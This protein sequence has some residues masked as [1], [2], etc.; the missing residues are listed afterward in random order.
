V[1][2]TSLQLDSTASLKE[3]L[4]IYHRATKKRQYS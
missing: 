3:V 2:V 1:K 4:Q